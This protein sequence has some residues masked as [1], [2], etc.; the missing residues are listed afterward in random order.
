MKIR[1]GFV[2]NSSS[3]SFIVAVDKDNSV[4]T[5][6]TVTLNINLLDYVHDSCNTIEQLNDYYLS[7]WGY[8]N[9]EDFFTSLKDDSYLAEGYN[10]AKKAIQ[11]GKD[12]LFG[13]FS[14]EDDYVETFLCQ[15]GLKG[16]ID[17]S[18][19]TIIESEGGY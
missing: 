1:K 4:K 19:I 12:V 6:C 15:N 18:K 9:I 3:S 5:K 13:S 2:S 17:E 7:N 14:D 16:Y 11:D 10:K 8:N